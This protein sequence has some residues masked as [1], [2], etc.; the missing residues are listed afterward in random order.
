MALLNNGTQ[1]N[2]IMPN[3]VKSHSLEMGPIKDLIGARDACADL[4]N[5]CTQPLG[6]IVVQ[7]QVDG[8]QGYDEDQIA[9]VVPNLLTFVER[10]PLILGTPTISHIVNIMKERD[11]HLGNAMDE[12]QGGPSLVCA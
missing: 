8:V 2:T 10:I 12:C 6:Y 5:A 4:G 11:G 7:V 1:M 3:Y 9:L